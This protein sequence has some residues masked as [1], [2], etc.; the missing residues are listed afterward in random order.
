VIEVK[1]L[2]K[3]YGK[4]MAVDHLSFTVEKGQIYGFLGPN[5]AGKSTTMNIMTGYLGATEG[6]I[7][8]DG[9]SIMEEPETAKA[10]IGYLP[11]LPPLYTDM[12]VSEYLQFV[13]ELKKVPKAQRKEQIE[14]VVEMTHLEDVRQ[15]VIKNLSKG[16]KQRVGLA[17][18]LLGFP[19]VIILDE[20]TVGLDPKQI[21]EIRDLIREL[22][23]EHTVI[24]SSHIL[25]EVQEICDHILIIHHGKLLA[26]GSA[27]ELENMLSGSGTLKLE[28]KGERETVINL[29]KGVESVDSVSHDGGE[30]APDTVLL[31]LTPQSGTDPREAIFHACAAANLP[32]LTMQRQHASL[33]QIFL[34]L[35]ADSESPEPVGEELAEEPETQIQEEADDHEGDL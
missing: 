33:E 9:H 32:I 19:P 3:R 15:R 26:S 4:H 13:A 1:N 8:I 11:E 23:R 21:I 7:L 14:R 27:A 10:S 2:V 6:E 35:T 17:Q 25:T 28:I 24:L 34:E 31:T 20:P 12:T 18:A 22:K 16:Y 5:G 30:S 29:L